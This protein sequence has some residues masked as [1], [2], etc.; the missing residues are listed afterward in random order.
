M[1]QSDGSVHVELD[2]HLCGLFRRATWLALIETTGFEVRP[3][4]LTRD[5]RPV[6]TEGF[7]AVR[8]R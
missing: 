3:V 4:P 6:G 2:E 7:L 1:T 8:P 5:E